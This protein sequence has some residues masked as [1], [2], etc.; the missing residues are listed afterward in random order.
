MCFVFLIPLTFIGVNGC[1]SLNRIS[2]KHLYLRSWLLSWNHSAE[3]HR[4]ICLMCL[5][6]WTLVAQNVIM[7]E[8]Q[9]NFYVH[10]RHLIT[11]VVMLVTMTYYWNFDFG[12]SNCS[13]MSHDVVS[14]LGGHW[15]QYQQPVSRNKVS[16]VIMYVNNVLFGSFG[17]SFKLQQEITYH[18]P[19]AWNFQISKDHSLYGII[20]GKV[21]KAQMQKAPWLTEI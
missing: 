15:G 8:G 1:L 14:M 3:L 18:Y 2:V 6:L 17:W 21:T 13:T 9:V 19:D 20:V 11:E 7:H 16:E 5:C 12:C 10:T 4:G